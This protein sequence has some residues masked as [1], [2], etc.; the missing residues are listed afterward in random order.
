MY[1]LM[2]IGGG[3][4]GMTC[5]LLAKQQGFSVC[6]IEPHALP[7]ED[8]RCSAVTLASQKIFKKIGIWEKNLALVAS[9]YTRM[10]VWDGAGYGDLVLDA[11]GDILEN[12]ALM[13]ALRYEMHAKNIEIYQEKTGLCAQLMIGADGARSTTRE[14]AGISVTEKSYQQTA[15]VAVV[16]TQ[17][18]H[19]NTA[20]QRFLPTGPLA[21]LPLQSVF[22]SSIVW[23]TTPEQACELLGLDD[24]LF[25]E[26][27]TQAFEGRLGEV[28]SVGKRIAFPLKKQHASRYVGPGVALIGDAAHVIHPL[29]GQGANLGFMDAWVLIDI[30]QKAQSYDLAV[31]QQYEAIRRRAAQKM[32]WAMDGLHHLFR[33]QASGVVGLRSMGMN[34][35]NQSTFLKK[36]FKFMG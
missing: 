30:L 9:T 34:L 5:A 22:H 32:M 16:E 14:Q 10:H 2:I 8:I 13:R 26:A 6:V 25:C 1:D 4:V 3:M 15:I 29:A 28:L 35:F 19:Q 11:T 33:S 18:P 23:S 7:V 36:Q 21:F 17:M 20:W 27:L 31:L 12:Q 24:Q